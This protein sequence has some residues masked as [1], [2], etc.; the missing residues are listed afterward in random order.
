MPAER[1]F[2]TYRAG[3]KLSD[4]VAEHHG[5]TAAPDEAWSDEFRAWVWK[6]PYWWPRVRG[7]SNATLRVHPGGFSISSR[8]RVGGWANIEYDWPA[9]VIQRLRPLAIGP[10]VLFEM[11]GELGSCMVWWFEGERLRAAL[12]RA[13]LRIIEVTHL[14]W[15]RPHHVSVEALGKHATQVPRAIIR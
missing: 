2:L 13:G 6:P 7:M 12:K 15:E 10:S 5:P 11:N 3:A 4:V 8:F 9:V 1:V 14:G